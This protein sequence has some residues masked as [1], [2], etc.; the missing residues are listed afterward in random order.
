MVPRGP[1]RGRKR[2]TD[3]TI[4]MRRPPYL[5]L[6]EKNR[7]R[8]DTGS[9]CPFSGMH[10]VPILQQKVRS[11]SSQDEIDGDRALTSRQRILAPHKPQTRKRL[12]KS[13]EIPL[14][15]W[16]FRR[17][18]EPLPGLPSSLG[19]EPSMSNDWT[20]LL[21]PRSA[22]HSNWPISFFDRPI[23]YCRSTFTRASHHV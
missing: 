3:L 5:F 16:L 9:Q 22:P 19:L 4:R 21:K 17:L 15:D 7:D 13:L 1:T 14:S 10:Q 6:Q 23:T 8:L 11:G 2:T 20:G 12:L 18:H